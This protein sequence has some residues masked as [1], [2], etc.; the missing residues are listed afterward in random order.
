MLLRLEPA[1][2][3]EKGDRFK[4]LWSQNQKNLPYE[5]WAVFREM[6]GTDTE[7]EVARFCEIDGRD[8]VGVKSVS[9]QL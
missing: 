3:L 4:I 1:S 6:I 8:S 5:A 2:N 9:F 7:F